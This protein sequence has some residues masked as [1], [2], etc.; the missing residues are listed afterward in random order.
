MD[1][2]AVV[3][4][5]VEDQAL[6]RHGVALELEKEAGQVARPHRPHIEI[7]DRSPVFGLTTSRRPAIHSSRSRPFS[8]P[9]EMGLIVTS[10]VFLTSG[11][12]EG[13]FDPFVDFSVEIFPEID[14]RVHR[15]RRPRP[16]ARRR[17]RPGLA[18][19]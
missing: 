3:E 18:R 17:G 15:P 4:P 8:A 6:P 1:V 5:E 16:E 14:G 7:S 12:P 9:A 13:Q 11:I 10:A 2:A 19:T